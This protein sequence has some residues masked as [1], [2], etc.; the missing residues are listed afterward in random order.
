MTGTRRRKSE[1]CLGCGS[2]LIGKR[3]DAEHCSDRCRA[4]RWRR[5]HPQESR[6]STEDLAEILASAGSV[7]M[8]Q[9]VRRACEILNEGRQGRLRVRYG[10]LE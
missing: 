3:A 8:R 10:R 7:A 2:L 1:R 6:L 5:E 9:T 4:R